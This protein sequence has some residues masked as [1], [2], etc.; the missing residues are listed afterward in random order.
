[1]SGSDVKI[2]DEVS[3]HCND[4]RSHH[5]AYCIVTKVKR[6]TFDCTETKGSYRAGK[7][8]NVHMDSN[9]SFNLYDEKGRRR[10]ITNSNYLDKRYELGLD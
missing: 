7:N 4:F 8:W 10:C 5:L 6:R 3:F 2:G 1:M 9:F